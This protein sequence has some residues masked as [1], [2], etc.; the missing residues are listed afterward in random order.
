MSTDTLSVLRTV[1]GR[2]T[3]QTSSR[4]GG[5]DQTHTFNSSGFAG[6]SSASTTASSNAARGDIGTNR[7]GLGRDP[8][9]RVFDRY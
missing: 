7:Q 1:T 5:T 2:Q 4:L 6:F 8:N 3:F 9:N